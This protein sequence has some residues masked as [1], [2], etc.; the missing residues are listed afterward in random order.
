MTMEENGRSVDYIEVFI[1]HGCIFLQ[2]QEIFFAQHKRVSKE[3]NFSFSRSPAAGKTGQGSAKKKDRHKKDAGQSV[4]RHEIYYCGSGV[5][6]IV[7]P[8]VRYSTII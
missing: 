1:A 4:M 6:S 3:S 2:E 5:L 7:C 8:T